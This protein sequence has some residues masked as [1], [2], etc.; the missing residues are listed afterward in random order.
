[1]AK[2]GLLLTAIVLSLSLAQAMNNM[3]PSGGI[4]AVSGQLTINAQG[5]IP[6]AYGNDIQCYNYTLPY[7]FDCP[8]SVA[9]G[10]SFFIQPPTHF[11]VPPPITCSSQ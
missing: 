7:V 10:I 4:N 1:M 9:I 5:D 2:S 6:L 8:P 11:K 3:C